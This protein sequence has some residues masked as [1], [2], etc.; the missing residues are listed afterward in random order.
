MACVTQRTSII[1]FHVV[2]HLTSSLVICINA[3]VM[4][5]CSNVST[6]IETDADIYN[7]LASDKNSFNIES[8]LYPANEPSSVLVFVNI[9]GQNGPDKTGNDSMPAVIKYTWSLRSLYA[10]FPAVFLEISS[11]FS[12]LVTPRTQELNITI[13]YFCCNVSKEDRKRMIK[14]ALATVSISISYF[15]LVYIREFKMLG[16]CSTSLLKN[17]ERYLRSF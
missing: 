6:C 9:Y 5:K 17:P 15:I 4:I 13:P 12:I 2:L 7:S 3:D 16:Q 10:A 1:V 14:N 8:A 11:L